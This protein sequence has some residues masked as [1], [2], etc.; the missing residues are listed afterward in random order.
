[1][2]GKRGMGIMANT[3]FSVADLFCGA[4][5]ESTGIVEAA[6]AAGHEIDLLAVNHWDLAIE[7]H[8][9][10]HPDARH[11]CES[12]QSIDPVQAVPRGRLQLLWA[13]PECT[14]HS[15][16]RGGRPKSDQSRASA[17]LILK[18]LQELYVEHV[19]IENVPEFVNW[20][21]L[22]AAGRTLKKRRGELFAAF[23][24]ALRALGYR[25][26]WR[27]LNAAD[28]G[29][30]TT[31]RRFFLQARRV[32]GAIRWPEP[33]HAEK[34]IDDGLFA[35]T[36]K[37]WVP[38]REIID[39]DVP[40]KSIFN[41]KKPLADATLARIECGIRKYW[42]AWA[43]PFL[44]I[45]RGTG[46]ARRVDVPLPAVTAG[47]QHLGLVEPMFIPQHGGGTV[48]P[49]S[50][51]L[52]TVA[53]AGSISL[54]E[55][56]IAILRGQSK[57]RG[58]DMP[59]PTVSC[60]GIHAGVIEPIITQSE[61]ANRVRSGAEPMPTIT[62]SS[63]GFGV[64][65]PFLVQYYGNGDARSVDVPLDTV[66]CRDRFGL[67]SPDAVE[68][69]IRFRMLLPHELAAAQGF[70]ADYWFAGNKSDQVKQIGNAVPCPVARALTECVVRAA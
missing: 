60:G 47:G 40:G 34:T 46:T 50:R 18:W 31:R 56:F 16:A 35:D 38:A 30:P 52:S 19:I 25:V 28:Y 48:K 33:T 57:T 54:V 67:V 69:D 44:V 21:P 39:W 15:N 43:E 36:R 26:D 70:P 3:I 9:R 23:L 41:R 24:N 51:P 42:G 68:L 59:L 64:A 63:R 27:V 49:V 53:T 29:A 65:R 8:T 22:D 32:K 37:R 6:R 61:H 5:G 55:P 62:T 66:T 11:L 10:N 14:H 1:M 17:W 45:L 12:I 20:G 7:T 58:I 13:S 4:G 2:T